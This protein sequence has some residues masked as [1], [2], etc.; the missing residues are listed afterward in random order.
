VLWPE[1]VC[2]GFL[3]RAADRLAGDGAL[4]VAAGERL[5]GADGHTFARLRDAATH[6]RAAAATDEAIA[7]E[8]GLHRLEWLSVCGDMLSVPSEDAA[9]E[10]ALCV[11]NDGRTLTEVAT[12][13]GIRPDAVTLYVGDLDTNLASAVAAA[14]EGELIGPFPREGGFAVVHVERK[15]PPDASDPEVRRRAEERIVERIVRRATLDHVER[16]E[17]L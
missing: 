17:P 13:L 14:R 16:H 10:A 9:R 8:I 11:R 5:D 4:A 3:L 1:A 15:A 7:R 12:E 2:S 6:A